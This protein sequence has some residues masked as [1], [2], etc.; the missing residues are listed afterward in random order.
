M[1]S[2]PKNLN[3][4]KNQT[5]QL[6]TPEADAIRHSQLLTDA[7]VAEI[8]QSGGQITFERYM[9]MVLAHPGLGYYVSGSQKFGASGDF[10][11]A[12]EI[13]PLFS[14][15]VARQCAEIL[16][17]LSE[18]SEKAMMEFGAGTGIMA[19]DILLEMEKIGELP[20]RYYIL[21][22]SAELK[23]R[24]R[25]TIQTKAGHLL[26]KVEWI[27]KLPATGFC[28]IVLANEVLD[29]MPVHRFFKD[30]S[31]T[32]QPLGEYYVAWEKGEFVLRQGPLS[33]DELQQSI[34]AIDDKLPE[35]Y[36]S[37]IN[38]AANA[39]VSSV[40]DILQN[41]VVLII[42]YGFPRHEYYHPD[43]GQG[44]LMC[45]YRH[46]SHTDVFFYPG[47]QDITAH[48]DFTAVA[49]A[50]N[51]AGLDIIGYTNQAFFLL[52][53]RVESYLQELDSDSVDYMKLSQ[54]L[55][56]LTMPG[57]MGELFKVIALGKRYSKPLQGFA[58][59]DDRM[60]L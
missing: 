24:Q 8:E 11:T 41:G 9:A 49:K 23:Q 39:W 16:A 33:S 53:N 34:S 13:S 14:Y 27:E 30:A 58:M 19:A 7:I 18:S 57:E 51:N 40:A 29:A 50:A 5:L 44:T 60:K 55:K 37:E 31:N 46:R 28:G 12:P 22:L 48:V 17:T 4:L 59:K 2:R 25:E 10:V 35:K 54:Q 45:H 32:G 56:T 36:S 52:G 6:P 26:N 1:Y 21:E 43:R 38:L 42:D 15:C 3:T 47:L 20:Q